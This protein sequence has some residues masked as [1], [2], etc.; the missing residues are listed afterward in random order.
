MKLFACQHCGQLLDFE[1]THCER[2]DRAL[3]YLPDLTELSALELVGEDRYRPLA[4]PERTVRYCANATY[5]VCNWLVDEASDAPMCAACRHNR[6]IPDLSVTENLVRWRRIESAKHRLFYGL[7]RLRL[8]L[9]SR[10]EDPA[11]LTFDFL[12]AS[13]AGSVDGE[14]VLTGHRAGVITINV[15]EADDVERERQRQ[16][17]AEPYRTL[18]GHFRHETG[19][20][21][22]DQLVQGGPWLERARE[23]VGR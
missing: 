12:A 7:M 23:L 8:P 2:C 1:N 10:A 17:F 19:H 13:G 3:G 22:W 21:Y 9:V 20:Y 4:V 18:L 16:E 14:Q 11:G 6:M 5:E 15:D